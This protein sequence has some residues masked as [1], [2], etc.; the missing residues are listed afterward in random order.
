M[1]RTVEP[2]ISDNGVEPDPS[3]S[4]Q[5]YSYHH[6]TQEGNEHFGE[7]LKERIHIKSL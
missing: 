5:K 1:M 7:W 6:V 2:I 4:I 3:Y